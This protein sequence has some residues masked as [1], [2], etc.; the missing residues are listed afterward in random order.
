MKKISVLKREWLLREIKK[1]AQKRVSKADIARELDVKPQYLNSILNSDRGVTDQFLDKFIEK[2]AIT[3]IDLLPTLVFSR[4]DQSDELE[5]SRKSLEERL[6]EI[7]KEKDSRIEEQARIIGHME[8]R[9][10]NPLSYFRTDSDVFPHDSSDTDNQN[11]HPVPKLPNSPKSKR[12][13]LKPLG[14]HE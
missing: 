14:D 7:I 2:Y 12:A 8:E 9:L 4:E 10:G 6:L 11:V 13:K 1:L 3:H 5:Q